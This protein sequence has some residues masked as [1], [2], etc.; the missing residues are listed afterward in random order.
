MEKEEQYVIDWL[1]EEIDYME[2]ECPGSF[3]FQSSQYDALSMAGTYHIYAR[4]QI[5]NI[6]ERAIY[7]FHDRRLIQ[8][9]AVLRK[10]FE[11]NFG[12]A[13]HDSSITISYE[14]H[15]D[16]CM[17]DRLFYLY[18]ME[19]ANQ[20]EMREPYY[21]TVISEADFEDEVDRRSAMLKNKRLMVHYPV[22]LGIGDAFYLEHEEGIRQNKN[23]WFYLLSDFLIGDELFQKASFMDRL[24]GVILHR[25]SFLDYASYRLR[26]MM[27]DWKE[28]LCKSE[29]CEENFSIATQ[30]PRALAILAGQYLVDQYYECLEPY[31]NQ[32]CFPELVVYFGQKSNLLPDELKRNYVFSSI[33]QNHAI[34]MFFQ[35]KEHRD[36]MEKAIERPIS[37]SKTLKN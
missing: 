27:N 23:Y 37:L 5:G 14:Y 26:D 21:Q 34:T 30:Y 4:S 29:E 18:G 25:Y 35:S 12:F 9:I 13:V 33:L 10:L 31:I 22:W 6:H 28:E 36:E 1:E 2:K 15:P 11:E 7:I 32:A 16:L 20:V 3:Y 24:Y 8:E 17:E 19:Y